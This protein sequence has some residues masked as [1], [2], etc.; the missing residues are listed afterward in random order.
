M[1][2]PQ[3][4]VGVCC[5]TTYLSLICIL[6]VGGFKKQET[7]FVIIQWEKRKYFKAA[8]F[9]YIE[10]YL[11]IS[12]QKS[13][14]NVPVVM[15][16]PARTFRRAWG[17]VKLSVSSLNLSTT[18]RDTASARTWNQI[19]KHTRGHTDRQLVSDTSTYKASY[20]IFPWNTM[21]LSQSPHSAPNKSQ[22]MKRQQVKLGWPP[23]VYLT[24][25]QATLFELGMTVLIY[26]LPSDSGSQKVET[27]QVKLSDRY[28]QSV[29]QCSTRLKLQTKLR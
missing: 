25:F 12:Q 17:E 1:Y 11:A 28:E 13:T 16:T 22:S 26:H 5:E 15:T 2:I 8:G 19:H 23:E 4:R 10:K 29:C 27:R 3:D 24:V 14:P 21:F 6:K 9:S 20:V 7:V 18:K